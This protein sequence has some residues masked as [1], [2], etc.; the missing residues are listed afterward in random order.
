[1]LG[2]CFSHNRV[3]TVLNSPWIFFNFE[4]TCSG[5]ESVCQCIFLVHHTQKSF[6]IYESFCD[7]IAY[8]NGHFFQRIYPSLSH[9]F[10]GCQHMLRFYWLW[11]VNC[12]LQDGVMCSTWQKLIPSGMSFPYPAGE[13][14]SLV[15]CVPLLGKHISLVIC[16]PLPGKHISLVLCAQPPGQHISLV[17]SVSPPW[18]HISVVLCVPTWDFAT[19]KKFKKSKHWHFSKGYSR[20]KNAF[21]GY[22]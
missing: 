3:C 22:N 12:K 8:G 13:H 9:Y 21:P 15:I 5:L 11:I 6:W 17:I 16:V 19:N 14:F 7:H 2:Q 4:C 20:T 18:K 1:M 10:K